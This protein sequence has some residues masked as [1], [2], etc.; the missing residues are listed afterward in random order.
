M[1]ADQKLKLEALQE[2]LEQFI[3]NLRVVGVIAGDF[4]HNGQ[5]VL[6]ERL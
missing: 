5:T 4:Q 1:A 2:H 3:E 6:N